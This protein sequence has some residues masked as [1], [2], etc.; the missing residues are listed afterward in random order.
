MKSFETLSYLSQL[1]QFR[2]LAY[3][4]LQQYPVKVKQ[5]KFINHGANTTYKVL[6]KEG[7]FLL[8][9]HRENYHTKAAINEELIWL[10]KLSKQNHQVPEPL[11]SKNELLVEEVTNEIAGISRFCSLLSWQEGKKKGNS[12]S[13][14]NM[15]ATGLL[16]AQLHKHTVGKKV[17]HRNY[18][19]LD[20][21][22]N[23][24]SK[25][26]SYKSL[27]AEKQYSILDECRKLTFKK[28]KQYQRK[29]P[30]KSALIHADMHFGN[31]VWR[32]N[33]P[34]PID[35]D[36]CGYGFY[37]YDLAVTLVSMHPLFKDEK[38]NQRAFAE[39]FLEGYSSVQNLTTDDIDIL[40]YFK[41]TRNL[42]MFLWLYHRI[43][44]PY[45][46]EYFKKGKTQKIAYF[47]K[48]L[49]KGP[50]PLI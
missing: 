33:T 9:V 26:G 50:D 27:Q 48:A 30:E 34:I 11:V 14:A 25:F 31:I 3:A 18:W 21:L 43:S 22:L 40:P 29:H 35:F 37:M 41:L 5:V 24:D 6:A 19:T 49:N 46:F 36:D 20:G 44:I 42:G 17:K 1:R 16:T 45:L 23:E 32:N 15:Y 39:S 13:M 8:R 7:I 47:K 2:K 28:I 4:A 38:N 12:L 10:Q